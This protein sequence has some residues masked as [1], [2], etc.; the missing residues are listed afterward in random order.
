LLE[1]SKYSKDSSTYS[2]H[3]KLL[4]KV[5]LSK[6]IDKSSRENLFI[7]DICKRV[8]KSKTVLYVLEIKDE[9]IG[10]ISLSATSIEDQP[11]MQID[12]I[13]VSENYRGVPLEILDNLKPFKYLI[14]MAINLAKK[15]RLEIGLRYLALS[16][17]NDEL[18]EKYKKVD[19]QSLNKDW[20]YFKI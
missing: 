20:M 3:T 17:D 15:L 13:F 5:K 7:K 10:F 6:D 16:P 12:Y 4:S 11:S 18:K 19:F 1:I 8:E 2:L 9:V 14:E